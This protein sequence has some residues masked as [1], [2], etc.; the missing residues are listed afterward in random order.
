[1]LFKIPTIHLQKDLSSQSVYIILSKKNFKGSGGNSADHTLYGFIYISTN[2]DYNKL[3]SCF[4]I[5][6]FEKLNSILRIQVLIK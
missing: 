4:P 2:F 1:M 5:F 6:I 3:N